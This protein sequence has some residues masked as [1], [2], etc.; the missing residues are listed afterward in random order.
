MNEAGDKNPGDPMKATLSVVVALFMMSV[1]VPSAAARVVQSAACA[2]ANGLVNEVCV[3][4]T[5]VIQVMA[6]SWCTDRNEPV[7]SGE[8]CYSIEYDI[9]GHSILPGLSASG[10]GDHYGVSCDPVPLTEVLPHC[11]GAT[12]PFPLAATSPHCDGVYGTA[13]DLLFTT[14]RAETGRVCVS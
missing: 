10:S 8:K 4:V 11:T 2:P 7:P 3:T 12:G 13:T 9:D 5:I 1:F 6:N 14:S